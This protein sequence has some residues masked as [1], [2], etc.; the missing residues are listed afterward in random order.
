MTT[1]IVISAIV[2]LLVIF[3]A[4][5]RHRRRNPDVQR[6]MRTLKSDEVDGFELLANRRPV[7]RRLKRMLSV[8]WIEPNSS[9]ADRRQETSAKLSNKK[10]R[11]GEHKRQKSRG[12][13]P[14]PKSSKRSAAN[15]PAEASR[16]R[17]EL[18][19]PQSAANV[20]AET[21]RSRNEPDEPQGAA[22]VQAEYGRWRSEFDEPESAGDLRG[23]AEFACESAASEP[24]GEEPEFLEAESRQSDIISLRPDALPLAEPV[25]VFLA[26]SAPQSVR[27]GDHF[28]ARFVAYVEELEQVIES[29]LAR[30]SPRAEHHLHLKRCRWEAGTLIKV[31]LSGKHLMV[32]EPEEQFIWEGHSNILDFDVEVSPDAPQLIT[33]LKFDAL[34]DD[35]V[36]ARLRLDLEIGSQK[37]VETRTVNG[38][39]ARSAFASYASKDRQRVLDRVAEIRRNGVDVFLDCLSLHPG[40]SWKPRL[41][42]E[43]AHRE[44][45]ILFWS[46]NAKRSKWVTWEWRTALKHRG[47]EGIEPHP[48]DPVEVASPPRELSDL[49]FGDP[50]MLIRAAYD[51]PT[52]KREG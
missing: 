38:E 48:L 41:E 33:V 46:A 4:I 21:S 13:G 42:Q 43:I 23:A 44:L 11:K 1:F 50:H 51:R 36:I 5:R 40:E 45:F 28:T 6:L 35:I 18:D 8:Q 20:A 32:G 49:H 9:N 3:L 25:P 19:E 15:I 24:F 10:K 30:L 22:S 31:Q 26:A 17:N 16:W 12:K 52:R 14:T 7:T 29:R 37:K 47:L 27:P 34:I 39:P 2:I